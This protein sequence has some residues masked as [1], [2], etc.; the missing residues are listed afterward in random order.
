MNEFILNNDI[1]HFINQHL[2]DDSTQLILKGSPFPRL[3]I[4]KIVEQIIAKKKCEKKLPTWF[5]TELIYYPNK[6]NIEQTSSEVTARYKSNLI[7]GNSLIDITGGFGVDCFYFSKQIKNITHCEINKDLSKIVSSNFEKLRVQNIETIASNGLDYLKK[8]NQKFDWIYVDPS[9]RNDV[10]GKVFLLNDCLPD[11]PK[12]LE[13]LFQY[14]NNILL[15]VAPLLD[16]TSTINELNFVKNIY[17]IAVNNEVKELL[18]ILQ[19]D[20]NNSIHIKAINIK[21]E[22]IETFESVINTT[23]NATY[24]L[25]KTFLYEPNSAILKAGLFNEISKK[26][27]IDKLHNNSHLY[28]SNSL[29]E[30]PGRRFKIIQ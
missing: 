20:Y 12:N 18:F 30:F 7:S 6:L 15:K 23:S 22:N 28:T 11:I 5:K 19:K 17:T 26:L 8:I 13:F 2:N 14:T 3:K 10:K 25:P 27:E 24:S 9:R 1:Q 21:K 16:I 4:Q 29:I